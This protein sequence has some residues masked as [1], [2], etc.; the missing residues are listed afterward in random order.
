MMQI[1]GGLI[2]RSQF[3]SD[4]GNLSSMCMKSLIYTTGP[5]K[6]RRMQQ[7]LYSIF[8]FQLCPV[9]LYFTFFFTCHRLLLDINPC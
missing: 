2:K 5:H 7:L 3:W 9:V 8:L 6:Q 1:T 4:G